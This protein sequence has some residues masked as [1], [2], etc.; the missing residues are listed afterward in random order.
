MPY[1]TAHHLRDLLNEASLE[2]LLTWSG[3]PGLLPR[4]P[5]GPDRGKAWDRISLESLR[6]FAR[7]RDADLRFTATVELSR[8]GEEQMAIEAEPAQRSLL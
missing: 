1:V 8:R 6:E 3:E 7:D 5:A 2:Q 4:V